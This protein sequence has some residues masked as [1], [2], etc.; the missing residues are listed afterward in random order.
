MVEK[1]GCV[2][3]KDL[4]DKRLVPEPGK[5]NRNQQGKLF[6]VYSITFNVIS[7]RI[8]KVPVIQNGLKCALSKGCANKVC[9]HP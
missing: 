9:E 7:V 1:Q 4:Y 3:T 6:Y 8:F 5:R 2:P